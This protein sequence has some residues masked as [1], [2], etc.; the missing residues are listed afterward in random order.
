[1]AKENIVIPTISRDYYLSGEGPIRLRTASPTRSEKFERLERFLSGIYEEETG[2]F[3]P[4]KF[5]GI[6]TALSE[7]YPMGMG[8]ALEPDINNE[9]QKI[10]VRLGSLVRGRYATEA[11]TYLRDKEGH[12]SNIM[13]A[14]NVMVYQAALNAAERVACFFQ[15]GTPQYRGVY[16]IGEKKIP[17]RVFE[18]GGKKDIFVNMVNGMI[19][20]DHKDD[21]M[22][23]APSKFSYG[24]IRFRPRWEDNL[25]DY[26][27]Y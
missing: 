14:R 17:F 19:T 11:R 4:D 5:T 22:E 8:F 9:Y 21:A 1:M 26:V 12:L 23:Q 16:M 24:E 15:L 13:D 18:T 3:F 7:A 20:M 6:V 27:R 25:K 10:P 2:E